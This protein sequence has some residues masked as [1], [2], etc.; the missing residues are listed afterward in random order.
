MAKSKKPNKKTD[1]K[2]VKKT[3][4]KLQG[5]LFPNMVKGDEKRL[6]KLNPSTATIAELNAKKTASATNK[7]GENSLP[8]TKT[9]HVPTVVPRR[10]VMISAPTTAQRSII[11]G[12]LIKH[13][14]GK[15]AEVDNSPHLI[16]EARAG[17]GKTTTLIHGLKLLMGL[18]SELI[19]SPQQKAVW[20]SIC[21]SK[22]KVKTVCFCAFNKSI[23]DE[24]KLKVPVGC[25]A[26]TMHGMGLKAVTRAFGNVRVNAKR[27]DEILYELLDIGS[28]P[29]EPDGDSSQEDQA[30]Y[31]QKLKEWNKKYYEHAPVISMVKEMVGLCKMNLTNPFVKYNRENGCTDVAAMGEPEGQLWAEELSKLASHYDVDLNGNQAK[32]FELTPKVFQACQDVRRDN[33]IN[34]DDMIWLPVALNLPVFKYDMLL[35]DEAQDLNRCQQALAKKA[36]KRLILCGDPCQP[37]GTQV[38]TPNGNV[39]IEDLKVG[40]KVV[41]FDFRG[42]DFVRSGVPVTGITVRKYK[43]DL[44]IV[45]TGESVSRYT[46]NH[47]CLV[48]FAPLRHKW[49]VYI[50][51]KDDSY[52]VGMSRVDHGMG[53]GSGPVMRMLSEEADALWILSFFDEQKEAAIHEQ[54]ITARWGIPQLRFSD[55]CVSSRFRQNDLDF[56]WKC[57][58]PMH[59]RVKPC[60]E[61]FGRRIQYPLFT[62][63]QIRQRSLKRPV[64]TQACNIVEGCLV[65]PYTG[66]RTKRSSWL[67]VRLS[68]SYHEG[69]VYSMTVDY[70]SHFYIGDGIVTHN[71]QAIYGFA[72]ADAESMS[73][74][75]KELSLGYRTSGETGIT[76]DGRGCITLPLTVT[77]RCGK[78]IV[79]EA[80][81]IVPDFE[82]HPDN[83]PGKVSYARF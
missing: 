25:E 58:G 21:L 64:V 56:V 65:L 9:S 61:H 53:L 47:H 33:C 16:V 63:D 45:D 13:L 57:G 80:K 39:N 30:R 60:F 42:C 51:R 34:F 17:T 6:P 26:M 66:K 3:K 11:A 12:G 19:P 50:M 72:G 70:K 28:K 27:V 49:C 79:D 7:E 1:K 77:R 41:S 43:D 67:P 38:L 73:R 59:D 14:E 8:P 23:A 2:P 81:K 46:V 76:G 52:R 31:T 37:E 10:P 48:S 32:A 82:S 78:A 29:V 40:D 69:K 22:D 44:V 15:T 71:C 55:K 24:L 20:D 74:M 83:G 75:I 4:P 18:D 36:G 68:R 5:S 54:V 62:K 35:V